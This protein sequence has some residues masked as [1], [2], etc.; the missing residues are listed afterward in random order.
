MQYHPLNNR[1]AKDSSGFRERQLLAKW[2]VLCSVSQ[3]ISYNLRIRMG[4]AFMRNFTIY[5]MII[6]VHTEEISQNTKKKRFIAFCSAFLLKFF[7][8]RIRNLICKTKAKLQKFLALIAHFPVGSRPT[9]KSKIFKII[10][11]GN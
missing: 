7:F 2:R 10:L 5:Y 6:F 11:Y 9:D 3:N 8:T 1:N 4:K